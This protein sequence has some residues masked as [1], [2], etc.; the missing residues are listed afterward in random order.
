VISR[1]Y[2]FAEK[3]KQI[4]RRERL[5]ALKAKTQ[6]LKATQSSQ[7]TQRKALRVK[8]ENPKAKS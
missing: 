1:V 4:Y 7:R 5:L 2:V 8:G 6:K 3:L